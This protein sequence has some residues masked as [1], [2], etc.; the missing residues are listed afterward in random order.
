MSPP[1]PPPP[2]PPSPPA[3][4][5]RD[6]AAPAHGTDW[7]DVTYPIS[8][9]MPVW[10]G[11]P[12]IELRALSTIEKPGDANV[13]FLGMSVH[14][15]TH[16]DAPGHY[17]GGDDDVAAAP[18]RIMV[19]RV[20]VAVISTPGHVSA[21]DLQQYE[22]RTRRLAA[23]ERVFFRTHNSDSDWTREPFKKDYAAIAPDAAKLLVDRGVDLAGVDYLSVAPFDDPATTHRLLLHARVWVIE[24]L[25]LRDVEEAEYDYLAAP[26]KILGSDASPLRVL[27]KPL[28]P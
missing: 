12:D 5:T 16:L 10:P 9:D 27:I 19:G 8:T 14:C 20:R 18:L 17:I 1:P 24:G 4:S 6:A 2:P 3:I 25:D 28:T 22:A 11:Q 13:S 21:H 15:G 7:Q 23:G 26:L